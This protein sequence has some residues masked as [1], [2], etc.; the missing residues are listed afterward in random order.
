M[1]LIVS[2]YA[3]LLFFILTPGI[4]ISFPSKGTKFVIAGVHALVFALIFHCT[5]RLVWRLGAIM[6]GFS[7]Y[8]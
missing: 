1:S 3:A 5:H 8:K 2:V 7:E 6:E 4:F